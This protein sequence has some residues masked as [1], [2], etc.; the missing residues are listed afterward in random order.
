MR[1][2]FDIAGYC[3]ISVDD[4]LD[5]DNVSIENQKAILQ[6]F[7]KQK[8]PGSTLTFYEDRDRSGY[9]FE[10]R[11]SY[12]AMRK[13]LMAHRYDILL[14][15]DFSRFS[16]RNSRGLVELEDLRDAGVRIISIGD[17]I[18]FPNDDD[19]LKIQFQFLINEMPVT[20]TS[21]KVRN[22]IRRRQAD[23][24]WICA[25]P[26]GYLINAR[27]EFE[28]VPT[29][30][31][32]V[33]T[34]FRL[35]NEEG[36]GYK[37][38]ANYLTEQG[39]PTP[40]MAERDRKEAAGM[41]YR[42]AVKSAWAIVTVQG[43]L[44]N[45]FYIGTLRQSKYTRQKINGKDIRQDEAE[46]IV[47]ERHHQPILEY[48]T[49]AITRALREKRSTAHYRGIK[50]YN[51]V[52]SGFLSCGDCGAPMFAMSRS[53]L[54]PAY[55]CGTYHRRGR[56]G[57]TSHHI[58][59]D[60]LD[61]LLK[62]YIRQV[63]DHSAD[64]LEQLNGDLE[65]EQQ[66]VAETERSA[67]HLAVVLADL[68]EELKVTKRQRIRDLMK[69][70]EQEA[71]LEETYDGLE[72][73]LQKK[74]EGIHHQIELLSDKRNTIIQVNRAARTAMEVFRDV[75][76]K[77][78]L[79]RN[80]LELIIRHIKVYEDHLE[81]QLQAD[82]DAILQSATEENTVNFKS[83]IENS[84]PCRIVQQASRR[85]D[86]IF[87]VHV[88]SDGD[89]LEIFTDRDGEVI[90]KKY[91]P[92]GEMGAVAGELAEAL[93]RTAGMSCAICDRD[94]VIAAAG[95]AKKDILEKRISAELEQL[96][97]Q[98]VVYER[99]EDDAPE[100]T[101]SDHDEYNVVVAV[102][103]ITEGDVSGCVVYVSEDEGASASEVTVKLCQTAAQFMAKRVAV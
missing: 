52:Y 55:T 22:V 35:Y 12:Q 31:E 51:N 23:G 86:K 10:Q 47:I 90:F 78:H 63:M 98:R 103:I 20:D 75:L 95:G 99:G 54:K 4:E 81:V 14:I 41:E 21:K 38:I 24:K 58:R 26:Y 25:A 13:E 59:A 74:I 82:V 92:M 27:Q 77:D 3:R 1:E 89:P 101:V 102:P 32:I 50:K 65:R 30:A 5:R 76:D 83:G 7:V 100:L 37:K 11:E 70:P 97:E 36:W 96:M 73:D 91:S 69:H 61:E 57:C 18:D 80:D 9:T 34:I 28:I 49:F 39:V 60:K 87:D 68:Q 8:F 66:D 56:A 71:L 2:T 42:R 93:A 33:R 48:R 15:K 94:A 46:Q 88:I 85:K 45:D 72:A 67:D 53:D 44:D 43:I 64:M 29:E 6:D 79:E 19:W 17:G 40:R 84:A 16:R 62:C